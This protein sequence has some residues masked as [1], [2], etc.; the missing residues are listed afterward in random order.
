MPTT[1][2]R[3]RMLLR[4]T[5]MLPTGG[6][7]FDPYSF[8]VPVVDARL[9]SNDFNHADTLSVTCDWVDTG[10][11]PRFIGNAICEFYLGAA[12]ER[13]E[14]APSR[15]NLRF[16]GRMVEPSRHGTGDS[17]S[18]QLEFHD[19][20]SFF[21]LTKPVKA[22]AVPT[23]A[24]TFSS[25]WR[26]ICENTPG[27]E[28]LVDALDFR[29]AADVQVGDVVGSRF[30]KLGASVAVNPSSDAWGMWKDLVGSAGLLT[31]FDLDRC[32]VASVT[33][34]YTGDDPPRIA[35]GR[36][37]LD[38]SERR[39]GNFELKG[40]IIQSVDPLGARPTLEG[41]YNP[42][43]GAK[44]KLSGKK[45][46]ARAK[47]AAAT[48]DSKEFDAFVYPGLTTQEA[49]D[50]MARSVYEQRARQQ[51][52]GS[53]TT[54]EMSVETVGGGQFDLLGLKSGDTID[55]RFLDSGDVEFVRTFQSADERARYLVFR[56]Y[57]EP[58]ARVIAA[59]VQLLGERGNLFYVKAV[60]TSLS[61]GAESGS[62][63]LQVDF[64]N[65][66][67]PTAGAVAEQPAA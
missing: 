62:F 16:V 59:N 60:T 12:D 53:L 26:R 67:D 33:D 18:V 42:L 19:Y 35:Y 29:G 10:L 8:D 21:L 1:I 43:K 36:S 52:E 22:D 40:V 34:Y 5:V 39:N 30:A 6:G 2:Y 48:Y 61:G 49:V 54:A 27:A 11:D 55:V 3:A 38:F 23:Y 31:F 64:C 15:D 51:L 58:V 44:K 65:K 41:S 28:L 14:W 7:N 37:L 24:D 17:I 45:V 47:A 50:Q 57:T 9:V 4:L 63:R 20:T 32:V 13:G 46:T 25:A 66:I 56:G